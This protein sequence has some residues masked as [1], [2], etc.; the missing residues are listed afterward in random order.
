MDHRT[1]EAYDQGA[2]RWLDTRYRSCDVELPAAVEFRQFV[3][4]GLI[5]DL[6]C[7]PGQLMT[8]LGRPVVGID[9]SA[10]MLR[11]ACSR[12][13]GP[14][15]CGDAEALPLP[16]RCASGVWANFSLQHLPR[17]AFAAALREIYRVLR[18]GGWVEI[19]MHNADKADGVR[20]DDDMPVGRWFTYWKPDDLTPQLESAGFDEVEVASLGFAHRTRGRRPSTT[21]SRRS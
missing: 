7:G 5:I 8:S 1:I 14:L 16:D 10:G 6:G 11:L 15:M 19:T 2:Q 3:G 13:R 12:G 4:P 20:A 21:T 18:G 9:A 17:A